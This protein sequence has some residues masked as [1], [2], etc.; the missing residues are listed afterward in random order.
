MGRHSSDSGEL[1]FVHCAIVFTAGYV[2]GLAQVVGDDADN[3]FFRIA[4]I[5]QR[6]F[7][8]A[9]DGVDVFRGTQGGGKCEQG[10]IDRDA[11]KERK[12]SKISCPE[13]L[14]VETHAMGRRITEFK[15]I[16]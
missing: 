3:E 15:R 8:F 16:L 6:V 12:R 9:I 4:D 11:V 2:H 5:A 1:E 10:W 13:M 7:G 14:I